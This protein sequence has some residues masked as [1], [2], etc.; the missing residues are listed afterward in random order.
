MKIFKYQID[1]EHDTQ[2][3]VCNRCKKE[4]WERIL[5]KAWKLIDSDEASS[6]ACE[7]CRTQ[8]AA[9]ALTADER[10]SRAA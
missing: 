6:H 8:D 1:Q 5:L 9:T 4:N 2:I 7:L 10:P 3:W